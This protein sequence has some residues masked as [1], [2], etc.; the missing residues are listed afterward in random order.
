[1]KDLDLL[2]ISKPSRY[3][4]GEINSI[5]KNREGIRLNFALAFPDVYEVGM[6]HLGLQILYHILNQQAEVACER[7]FV[8]WPDMARLMRK[9]AQ[10]LC[11]LE[12]DR[13]LRD[14][15]VVGFSLL[16]EL[17]YTGVLNILDL[18][19]IP[20]YASARN[21]KDPLIIGGGP[22]AMNPEPLADFFDAFVLGDGEEV[23]LE[24]CREIL[25]SKAKGEGKNEL[26]QRLSHLNGLYIPSFFRVEYAPDH[27]VE[28]ISPLI[29]GY[30][31]IRRRVLWDLKPADYPCRPVLPFME[32]I[33][34][35]LNI[36]VAR[37]CTRG[38]RFCQAGMIYRPLRER[39]TEQILEL[40]EKGLKS[41]GYDEVSLLSLSTGDYSCIEPLLCRIIDRYAG[42]RVAVS[43]PSLRTETLTPLLTQ[44]IQDVRKTGFTLAPEAGSQRLRQ[45]I[46]KG[47]AEEDLLR[48]IETVFAAGWRLIKLYFMIGLPTETEEDVANIVHLTQKAIHI[49]RRFRGSAQINVSISTFIPKSHTPF[50]WESQ[51]KP[52][53]IQQKQKFLQRK[54]KQQGVHLK[55][56]DPHLSFL[57]G[58]FARGD[59]RLSRVLEMA[60]GLGCRLDGWG[61]HFRYDLWEKAFAQAGVDPSFYTFRARDL[62]ETLPW[63]HLES[64][65]TK[66]FLLEERS[67]AFQGILTGDCRQGSCNGCGICSVP[68]KP[69]NR[70]ATQEPPHPLPTASPL[71]RGKRVPA[72][73]YRYRFQFSKLGGARFLGHLELSKSMLRAL[74]R[75]AI[76]FAYTQGFHPHPRVSFGPPIAVGYES[77]S[78]FMDLY[79]ALPLCLPEVKNRIN[80]ELPLG[81]KIL[82]VQEIPLKYPSIFDNIFQ[83]LYII[84]FCDCFQPP[85]DAI[86]HFSKANEFKVFWP[87]KHKSIDLRQAVKA[88]STLG[89][90]ALKLTLRGGKEDIPKPGEILDWI[91]GWNEERP[92]FSIRKYR[93]DFQDERCLMKS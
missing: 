84:R 52:E 77:L 31:T 69:G 86:E 9:H 57:E 79:T 22:C 81:I 64:G 39:S 13:P 76:P 42:Q 30:E 16:Y 29:A 14:F 63:E 66:K 21:E 60:Y 40:V 59:R 45:V 93:V 24:I 37:G 5:Q 8:P 55:W 26:L 17:N 47:N 4:G 83:V 87:R 43:L 15:D 18:A 65:I 2:S 70:T 12:S 90:R 73:T 71:L 28:K 50:Q 36:E 3:V 80:Q 32:I 23:I 41:T 68:A 34:D 89:D 78:E 27:R 54:L 1:M 62:N 92:R 48:S 7:V 19:G 46:N 91:F 35:R 61:D 53:E 49:A 33:H 11:S 25:E 85:R 51:A 67:R 6:S 44:K 56:P 82:R 38:C 74:R 20:L 72:V 58:V 88:L 75:A 10:P